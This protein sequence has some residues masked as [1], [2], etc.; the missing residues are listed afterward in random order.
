MNAK[1]LK[2]INK[3]YLLLPPWRKSKTNFMAQS[4]WVYNKGYLSISTAWFFSHAS[5]TPSNISGIYF[6]WYSL[7]L[8]LLSWVQNDLSMFNMMVWSDH[9]KL[10]HPLS[11]SVGG[12]MA[13]GGQLSLVYAVLGLLLSGRDMALV[14]A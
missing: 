8:V 5:T 9:L 14:L 13:N 4:M 11:Y 1:H 3:C 6:D 2:A 12:N 10:D 7:G